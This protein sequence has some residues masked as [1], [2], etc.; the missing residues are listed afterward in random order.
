[1][2]AVP[3]IIIK[4]KKKLKEMEMVVNRIKIQLRK[5]KMDQRIMQQQLRLKL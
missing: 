5:I 4:I 1:M 3:I 2:S